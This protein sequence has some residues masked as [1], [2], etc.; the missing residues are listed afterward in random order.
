LSEPLLFQALLAE[1][2]HERQGPLRTYDEA[3]RAAVDFLLS[4]WICGKMGVR[5]AFV[6]RLLYERNEGFLTAV[7]SI[8]FK[9]LEI[10]RKELLGMASPTRF[11]LVLP[12]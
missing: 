8:P 7:F 11:E 2:E 10:V 12:P 4:P 5:L 9:G 1:K 3:L 6:E